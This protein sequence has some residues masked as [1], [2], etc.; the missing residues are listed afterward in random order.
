MKQ[1]LSILS[2]LLFVSCGVKLDH[3]ETEDYQGNGR[4]SQ[5]LVTLIQQFEEDMGVRI[6]PNL[7]ITIE[8]ELVDISNS[9]VD[10]VCWSNSYTGDGVRVE[11]RRSS[12]KRLTRDAD[13]DEESQ[14]S[15]EQL[16]YHE[17]GHCVLNRLDVYESLTCPSTIM[18]GYTFSPWQIR[19]CYIPEE[20]RRDYL[21]ELRG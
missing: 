10:A 11:I 3:L 1:L 21:D 17:L 7:D 4:R 14:A 5:E 13:N 19:N 6:D 18:S 20:S 2:L 12:W 9:N 8:D 16:L 15:Q